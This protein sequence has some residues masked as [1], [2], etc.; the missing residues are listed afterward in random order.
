VET[1]TVPVAMYSGMPLAML[2]DGETIHPSMGPVNE[3]I[4]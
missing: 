4:A 1:S 3:E 2:L